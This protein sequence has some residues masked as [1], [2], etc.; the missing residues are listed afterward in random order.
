[1][2]DHEIAEGHIFQIVHVENG[3]VFLFQICL[4]LH[5]LVCLKHLKGKLSHLLAGKFSAIDVA[6]FAR[7]IT[8]L[9]LLA[10]LVQELAPILSMYLIKFIVTKLRYIREVK[11]A[12][13]QVKSIL[14]IFYSF[15][16]LKINYRTL[17]TRFLRTFSFLRRILLLWN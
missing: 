4:I 13:I 3:I 17:K 14:T 12:V 10:I 15:S 16:F 7:L 9:G 1:M 11:K 2:K 6:G 5:P 8:L